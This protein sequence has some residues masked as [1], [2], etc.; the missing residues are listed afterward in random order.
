[1]TIEKSQLV[2]VRDYEISDKNFVMATFLRGLY[3]GGYFWG[4]IPKDVFMQNYHFVLERLLESPNIKIKIACL[5]DDREVI[6]GYSVLN[7]EETI[8]H[9]VFTKSAWRNIG[10]AK[11]LLPKSI[12]AVTHLSKSGLSILRK[13]ETVHFN[14]FLLS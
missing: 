14:P 5:K 3:Y 9:W 2:A 6:L 12:L 4:E 11:S 10:I 7:K 13:H 1:M 8:L